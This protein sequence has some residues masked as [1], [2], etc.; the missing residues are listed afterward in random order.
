LP[1]SDSH[2]RIIAKILLATPFQVFDS[3]GK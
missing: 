3:K 2:A 1:S